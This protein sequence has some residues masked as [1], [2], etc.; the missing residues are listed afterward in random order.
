MEGR[1]YNAHV[2]YCKAQ[3]MNEKPK[4]QVDPDA[5]QKRL[6]SQKKEQEHRKKVK[7]QVQAYVDRRSK[8]QALEKE[9]IEL[10]EGVKKREMDIFH[11]EET[12]KFQ[13]KVNRLSKKLNMDRISVF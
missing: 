9:L 12:K 10:T 2:I 5:V 4:E 6:E 11:A 3:K 7:E 1:L 8:I 13:E